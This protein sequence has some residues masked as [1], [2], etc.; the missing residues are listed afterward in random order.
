MLSSRFIRP[1]LIPHRALTSARYAA[2]SSALN[3][4]PELKSARETADASLAYSHLERAL[5]IVT[6]ANDRKLIIVAH[7]HLARLCHSVGRAAA[8]RAHRV[9]AIEAL[10]AEA[11]DGSDEDEALLSRAYGGLALACLRVG[12]DESALAAASAA[13]AAEACAVGARGK[14]EAGLLGALARPQGKGQRI[15]LS[16][17]GKLGGEVVE[18]EEEGV[19]VAGFA[20]FFLAVRAEKGDGDALGRLDRLVDRWAGRGFDEVEVRVAAAREY[21][22]R[23]GEMNRAE[24]LLTEALGIAE[25]LG[26]KL[27]TSEPVLGLAVLYGAMERKIEAEGM[28]RSVED[29]F[30][31]LR[32]KSAFTVLTAEI[33]CRAMEEFA[34]FLQKAGR[35]KEAEVKRG[36]ASDVR[37]LF[38]AVLQTGSPPHVP[39]W[40]VDSCI[41]HFAVP[42]EI[43][44]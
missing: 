19:D 32:E 41:E 21:V 18:K 42:S 28:F 7:G 33:Y 5:E 30:E 34:A 36:R 23:V 2:A 15:L 25:K 4:L 3:S 1:S 14:V 11:A 29:R 40:F 9:A 44:L 24:E 43:M 31:G 35:D 39:F 20:E 13:S 16:A 17:V 8:E 22:F 37:A 10:H 26:N 38:P 6:P 12:G 27:D